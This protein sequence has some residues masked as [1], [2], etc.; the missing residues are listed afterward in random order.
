MPPSLIY[1]LRLISPQFLALGY[2][3]IGLPLSLTG[4]GGKEEGEER[5]GV[6]VRPT[7]PLSSWLSFTK[8]SPV[9]QC[10]AC[11]LP[12]D[13]QTTITRE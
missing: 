13:W 1:K 5:E 6:G 4:D 12:E 9:I 10:S 8:H 2:S 7:L 11:A 3:K